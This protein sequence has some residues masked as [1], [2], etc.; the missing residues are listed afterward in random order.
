MGGGKVG[1][2]FD[3]R[4]LRIEQALKSPLW[5]VRGVEESAALGGG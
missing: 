1:A 3:R 2:G 5:P 4:G